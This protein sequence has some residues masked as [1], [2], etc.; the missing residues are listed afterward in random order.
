MV[1]AGEREGEVR[2]L[3]HLAATMPF[4]LARDPLL[5]A[6][7]LRLEEQEHIAL[8]TMHHIISDGWSMGVLIEELGRLYAG[9]AAGKEVER[10]ALPVQ[11]ADY[12]LWQRR[13]LEGEEL[14][15][16]RAYWREQ[17]AG[18]PAGLELP[19]DHARPVQQS[20]RGAHLPVAFSRELSSSLERLA[21]G[22]GATL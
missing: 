17:L 3:A 20:F 10:K 1:A 2:R 19:L 13:W 18:A 15:R 9:Y 11:Y 16:H 6:Q 8:L 5:R 12:A 21:R 14:Q 22:E 7:L 4:D